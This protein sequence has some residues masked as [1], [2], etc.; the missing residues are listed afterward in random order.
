MQGSIQG[1][2]EVLCG[3]HDTATCCQGWAVDPMHS[4]SAA[5]RCACAPHPGRSSWASSLPDKKIRIII[6]KNAHLSPLAPEAN[7]FPCVKFSRTARDRPPS[8]G[9]I[10]CV[11]GGCCYSANYPLIKLYS[12]QLHGWVK[13]QRRNWVRHGRVPGAWANCVRRTPTSRISHDSRATNSAMSE[14][15]LS[16]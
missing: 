6:F 12:A 14:Y 13:A 1:N 16:Q 10:C 9:G 11:A 7:R 8:K 2:Q 4:R 15:L 5:V 3:Q